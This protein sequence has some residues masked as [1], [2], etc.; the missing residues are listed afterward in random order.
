MRSRLTSTAG[1][2]LGILAGVLLTPP[3]HLFAQTATKN[4]TIGDGFNVCQEVPAATLA[5]AQALTVR[6]TID[7]QLL[8]VTP[9]WEAGTTAGQFRFR[10]P[11]SAWPAAHK[12]IGRHDY[13][14]EVGGVVLADGTTAGMTVTTDHYVVVSKTGP[15]VTP[16]KWIKIVGSIA[17]V[18][19]G[20]W[21]AF[22]VG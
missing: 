2:I 1:L 17:A 4:I 11:E 15:T 7:N 13:K 22:S 12:T 3:T 14:L 6:L 20:T 5:E 10:F 19:F 18:V 16:P 9:V 21:L 8:A